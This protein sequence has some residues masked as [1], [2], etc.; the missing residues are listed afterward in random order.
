MIFIHLEEIGYWRKFK[1]R[2][3]VLI[4]GCARSGTTMLLYVLRSFEKT[5]VITHEEIRATQIY[6]KQ[7][8]NYIKRERHKTLVIK[9]PMV[10]KK[11]K[12]YDSIKDILN[13][14]Y[15]IIYIYRDGR[16]VIVS[17]HPTK[18]QKYHVA[19]TRWIETLKE[20]LPYK[21]HP[22]VLFVKYEEFVSNPDK[23]MDNIS[24]FLKLNYDKNYKDFY[25]EKE[26]QNGF[27]KKGHM[28]TG[29]GDK[30]VRPIA[31]DSIG[32]WKQE[33]HR[34][35]MEMLVNNHWPGTFE[36][37][38]NLLIAFDYEKDDSWAKQFKK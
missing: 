5:Q 36:P 25:K 32:N 14:N 35:R 6:D 2:N 11:S 19:P 18:K 1:M 13:L 27:H 8:P 20:S 4:T 33:Q 34:E 24:K 38:C 9:N 12:K 17:H 30:G 22:K 3:K 23:I 31:K 7:S 15:Y 28:A 21:N 37:F 16:D 10:F 26:I 29:L